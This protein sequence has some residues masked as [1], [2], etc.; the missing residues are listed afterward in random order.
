MGCCS[1]K[2]CCACKNGKDACAFG[3]C[4]LNGVKS[5]FVAQFFTFLGALMSLGCLFDCSFATLSYSELSLDIFFFQSPARASSVGFLFYGSAEGYCDY[6]AYMHK[7]L[8]YWKI[9][10]E[11]WYTAA[12]LMM[13]CVVVGWCIFLYSLLFCCTSQIKCCRY[14]HGSVMAFVLSVCQA[15][16]FLVYGS[17]VCHTSGCS[18]SRGSAVS[19]GAIFCYIIAGIGFFSSRDYPGEKASIASSEDSDNV[20]RK[21]EEVNGEE[22][23]AGTTSDESN[24]A[25]VQNEDP[26]QPEKMEPEKLAIE[27]PAADP[28]SQRSPW[29]VSNSNESAPV[30]SVSAAQSQEID[31]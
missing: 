20:D 14:F 26:E 9:M 8:N 2:I 19:L 30:I 22:D 5:I 17:S 16:S 10:G 12:F 24:T 18:F 1:P 15:S 21:D 3:F 25:T 31:L 4:Y 29:Q 27:V 23:D 13:F 7:I 28:D 6:D 11:S